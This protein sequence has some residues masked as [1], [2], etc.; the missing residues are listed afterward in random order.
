MKV[1]GRGSIWLGVMA[2][3]FMSLAIVYVPTT[4]GALDPV[5]ATLKVSRSGGCQLSGVTGGGNGSS[6]MTRDGGKGGTLIFLIL[7]PVATNSGVT[8]SAGA[9][10]MGR[11]SMGGTSSMTANTMQGIQNHE[12]VTRSGQDSQDTIETCRDNKASLGC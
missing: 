12:N 6:G 11:G 4:C 9:G 3:G 1:F 10:G 2:A 7:P 5:P 8:P